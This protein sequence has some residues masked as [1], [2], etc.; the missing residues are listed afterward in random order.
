M[1]ASLCET[2]F[3]R[4]HIQGKSRSGVFSHLIRTSYP[5]ENDTLDEFTQ[6]VY[7][8]HIP[9]K[10][11]IELAV[12]APEEDVQKTFHQEGISARVGFLQGTFTLAKWKG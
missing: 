10:R 3:E 4:G 7:K 8:Q 11:L 5:L 2:G 6:K 12:Y 1:L 9:E